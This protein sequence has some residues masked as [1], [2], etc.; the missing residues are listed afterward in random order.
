MSILSE[1]KERNSIYIQFD[2]LVLKI[3]SMLPDVDTDQRNIL[4][5]LARES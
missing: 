2:V 5:F 3:E 1:K 4:M